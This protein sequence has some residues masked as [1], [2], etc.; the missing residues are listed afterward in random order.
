MDIVCYFID[1][2]VNIWFM[3]V[4]LLFGGLIVMVNIGWFEDFVFIIK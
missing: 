3:V 4:I 1:K 2:L